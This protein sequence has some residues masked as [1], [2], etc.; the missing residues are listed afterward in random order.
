MFSF[1]KSDQVHRNKE[2]TVESPL[3]YSCW[4][5]LQCLQKCSVAAGPSIPATWQMGAVPIC[6]STAWQTMACEHRVQSTDAGSPLQSA[7]PTTGMTCPVR[8]KLMHKFLVF[9]MLKCSKVQCAWYQNY[10]SG[11]GVGFVMSE[12][13]SELGS[14]LA[15]TYPL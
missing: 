15:E 7:A 10:V 2:G 6:S 1:C 12:G 5:L 13:A 9:E 4:A 11:N 8:C 3:I 14:V